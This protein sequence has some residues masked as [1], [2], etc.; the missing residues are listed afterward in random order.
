MKKL[1]IWVIFCEFK[2]EVRGDDPVAKCSLLDMFVEA[3]P[4]TLKEKTA[5]YEEI[6]K[7]QT[8]I[9]AS[10]F[11]FM[12]MIDPKVVAVPFPPIT[13]EIGRRQ[14]TE[15]VRSRVDVELP[16]RDFETLFQ[17]VNSGSKTGD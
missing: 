7:H 5:Q 14:L 4:D 2:E 17:G 3:T 12:Q 13:T 10:F 11:Q 15:Y 9:H 6:V 16:D 1:K 8:A